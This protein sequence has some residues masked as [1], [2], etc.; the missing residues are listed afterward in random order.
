MLPVLDDLW[1]WL[2]VAILAVLF[3]VTPILAP[4][5]WA[6]LAYFHVQHGIPLLPVAILGAAGSTLGRVL[7]ALASRRIGTR[8]IPA[9]RRADAERA[10]AA[11]RERRA[12]SL[13]A[14]AMFAIGPIPKSLLFMSA[15]IARMP[16][17]PGAIVYGVARCAIY[18]VALTAASSTASSLGDIV[19]SPVGGPLLIAAQ[20]A[21]VI[22]V[23][24]LFRLDLPQ[25]YRRVRVWRSPLPVFWTRVPLLRRA[26]RAPA[27]VFRDARS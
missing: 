15:G 9:R 20:L 19:T 22:G 23:F 6:M 1:G 26:F 14:L 7:L 25:L 8:I 16:L 27:E 12:L 13:P 17:A 4:P 5:T 10:V 11:I 2:L 3:N 18:L 21:S 24:L